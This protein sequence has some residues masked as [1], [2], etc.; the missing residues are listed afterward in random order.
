MSP[1]GRARRSG[2]AGRCAI[3]IPPLGLGLYGACD[4]AALLRSAAMSDR[5]RATGVRDGAQAR[6]ATPPPKPS[7][8]RVTPTGVLLVVAL[9][10]SVAYFAYALTVREATQIPLLAAGLVVL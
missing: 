4:L 8:F 3:R 7:G 9:V 2:R 6:R 1:A 5:R 10:G